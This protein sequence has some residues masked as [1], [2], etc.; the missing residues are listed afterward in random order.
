LLPL[1]KDLLAEG[2]L[3]YDLEECFQALNLCN[4]KQITISKKENDVNN[5]N[6]KLG[7]L[8]HLFQQ[9]CRLFEGNG[10][11]QLLRLFLQH[12]I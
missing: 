11:I 1:Q 3:L 7:L 8:K 9:T 10:D 4:T 12:R 2:H 5:C 6:S